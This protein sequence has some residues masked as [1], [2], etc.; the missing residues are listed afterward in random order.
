MADMQKPTPAK[1][2]LPFKRTVK[3]KPPNEAS[4]VDDDG[5]ALFSQSKTYFPTVIK[6][7]QKRAREER[8]KAEKAEQERKEKLAREKEEEEN[9]ALDAQIERERM[10]KELREEADGRDSAKKRRRISLL[11]NDEEQMSD[12]GRSDD[13]V[14]TDRP[15]KSYKPSTP[16]SP[17]SRHGPSVSRSSR[18]PE[19][20][21]RTRTARQPESLVVLLDSSDDE[22]NS[23][24]EPKTSDPSSTIR[25]ASGRAET[26]HVDVKGK[27][28]ANASD[29]DVEMWEEKTENKEGEEED[30]SES[31]IKAAMERRRKAEEAR[32]ARES[33]AAGGRDKD[34]SNTPGIE[35]ERGAPVSVMIA[36]PTLREAKVLCCTV[37]TAQVLQIAFDTFKERQKTQTS[38]PH[39]IISELIFTWRGDRVYHTSKLETLGIYPRGRDGRLYE[40]NAYGGRNAPEGYVGND[41]V[42]FEA[43]T[44]EE[45]EENQQKRERERKRREMGEWWDEDDTTN[46]DSNNGSGQVMAEAKSSQKE[47]DRVKVIFKARNMPPRNITLRKYST[48]A[49]MIKAFRK[50]ASIDEDKEVEIRWDGET[51]DLET[52]VEEADIGEMDSVE[53]HIR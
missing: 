52:T 8:E 34:N 7:Q 22:G 29:S 50:L 44:P 12:D 28:I 42:Y 40:N 51:L 47:D 48:V 26:T 31:Y 33:S 25:S 35:D 27:G 43:W 1:R 45:Y 30:P 39:K 19:R 46:D 32:L 14:F 4:P 2:G 37:R 18:A 49:H 23:M 13:D 9:R 41:K 24:G 10:Q 6:D 5:L 3:R 21:T 36:A 53:V 17:E 11:S 38:Y 16:F 20:G 15:L